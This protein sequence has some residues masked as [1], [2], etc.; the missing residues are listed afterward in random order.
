MRRVILL[1]YL[2]V[3]WNWTG[4]SSRPARYASEF[5]HL[6][7]SKISS[8]KLATR[9]NPETHGGGES[10]EREGRGGPGGGR[11]GGTSRPGEGGGFE[12]SQEEWSWLTWRGGGLRTRRPSGACVFKEA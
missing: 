9:L 10:G 1:G 8:L 2:E 11:G 12:E 7:Y 3:C 6:F 5:Q 4:I